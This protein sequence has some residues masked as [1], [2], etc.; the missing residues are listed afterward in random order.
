MGSSLPR[1][2]GYEFLSTVDGAMQLAIEAH[3][4]QFDKQGQPYILHPMR[5]GAS[6]W[7]FGDEF[8]I[9]G[10]I[11][12][13]VEDSDVTLLDLELWGA[14]P[15]VVSAVASVTKHASE[16]NWEAYEVSI[17]KAM[18]DPIGMWVK[19]ADVADNASRLDGIP[20]GPVRKRLESKYERAAALIASVIPGYRIGGALRP[21][22]DI[23]D[24]LSDADF[25][26]L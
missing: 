23:L 5:V 10:L 21:P 9:A 2:L 20:W 19:A 22:G 12:D 13:V 17:R 1:T 26:D 7:R 4:G 15:A 25:Q 16:A 6:L 3:T 18:S 11:H 8:V 24:E 14:S